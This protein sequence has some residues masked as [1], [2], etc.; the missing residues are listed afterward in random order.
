MTIRTLSLNWLF[1]Y[2]KLKKKT[3][4]Q[5]H[6]EVIFFSLEIYNTSQSLYRRARANGALSLPSGRQLARYTGL[7]RSEEGWHE[8]VIADMCSKL[9]PPGTTAHPSRFH[10]GLA[11]DE[12]TLSKGLLYDR[13]TGRLKGWAMTDLHAEE[14]ELAGLLDKDA[15]LPEGQLA[16]ML[17]TKVFQVSFTSGSSGVDLDK[18]DM[19][20]TFTYPIAYAFTDGTNAAFLLAFLEEGISRLWLNSIR[21]T[22]R[23]ISLDGASDNRA[24]MEL[25]SCEE[26]VEYFRALFKLPSDGSW[27]FVSLRRHPHCHDI[28]IE[29]LPDPP[30]LDKKWRNNLSS[31]CN[32]DR[33]NKDGEFMRTIKVNFISNVRCMI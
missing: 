20:P 18:E 27:T 7:S 25:W 1:R 23:W 30:H 3:S 12:M 33:L 2:M 19:G 4:M 26:D 28:A 14:E 11:G 21:V 9:Q 15:R 6:S 10:G 22:V 31:S 8:S 16:S 24:F 5:W 32:P 13:V 29:A 17:A